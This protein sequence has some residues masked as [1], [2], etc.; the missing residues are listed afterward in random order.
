MACT[1]PI[2]RRS[3]WSRRTAHGSRPTGPRRSASP[4]EALKSV[5]AGEL[6]A[7]V[8]PATSNEEGHLV[9]QARAR[10]RQ[11]ARRS[12]PAPARFRRR[13]GG[14]SVRDAGRRHREG[15]R[16]RARRLQSAQRNAAARRAHPQGDEARR[17]GLRDQYGRFRARSRRLA[18]GQAHRRAVGDGA[19]C[20]WILRRR[21]TTSGHLPESHDLAGAISRPQRRTT[22]R[23]ISIEAR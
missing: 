14:A 17:E 10:A 5:R 19:A 21:R 7:L 23:R 18:A 12:S 16:D 11:R 9:A 20:C 2:A 13:R 15:E 8:H 6:G 22:R 3:R 1:R 4:S